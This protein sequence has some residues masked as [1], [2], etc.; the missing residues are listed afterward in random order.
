MIRVGPFGVKAGRGGSEH[1]Y[2]EHHRWYSP[3][4]GRDMELL[5]YGKWGRP[6]LAFPTSTGGCSQ[7][8]DFGLFRGG[9]EHKVDS[10][11]VQVCCVSTVDSDA[12]AN[13]EAH[14]G[15]K[16]WRH[17]QYDSYL[18]GEVVPMIRSKAERDDVV[19]FGASLG[20]FHSANF[21][22][23]HP[24]LVSRC[25]AFSGMYDIHRFLHGYW[26]D[27][28]YFNCPTAFVPNLPPDWVERLKH[29]GFVIATG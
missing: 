6:I 16:V 11:E 5:W 22:L 20:G 15:W 9:L 2:R 18:E 24:D 17:V 29:V 19:T 28:C 21:A 26:D 1:M 14:P 27:L 3:S 4:L 23:R 12:W 8:E 25:I 7:N 13:D 10:G